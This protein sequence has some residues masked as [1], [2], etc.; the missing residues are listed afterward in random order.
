MAKKSSAAKSPA[1]KV[2]ALQ[3]QVARH[4]ANYQRYLQAGDYKTA[5][6]EAQKARQI[7]SSEAVVA[8]AICLMRLGRAEEA[9]ALA[10]RV[11]PA[12]RDANFFDLVADVCGQLGK[13]EEG[14]AYGK[15]ALNLKDQQNATGY[16]WPLPA[17]APP[18]FTPDPS[19]NIVAYSL[20]GSKP[21]YC[22]G[23]VLNCAAV[24]K[25]L[26]GWTCRFY[27]DQ[28]VPDAVLLRLREAGAQLV[29]VD[30]DT[31]NQV[32]PLMWRFLVVDSPEVRRF[33]IRDADSVVSEREKACIE[34]WLESPSW[35]HLIRDWYTHTELLLAGLWGG[36]TGVFPDMRHEIVSFMTQGK[37]SASHYDQHFLRER[38]WPTVRQSVLSHDSQFEFF[39]NV[40]VPHVE[41]ARSDGEYHIGANLGFMTMEGK[42]THPDGTLIRWTLYDQA[43]NPVCVY[44]TTV[45]QQ[46][47]S[48]NLPVFYASQISDGVCKVRTTPVVAE[49]S[50]S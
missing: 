24:A 27:H 7:G 21:R 17:A 36:C 4:Y 34:A 42:T 48:A 50:G 1:A 41:G 15:L 18:A 14:R 28:S 8:E 22:E 6:V 44:E 26:P 13:T 43:D 35:F 19:A 2:H 11:P 40:P 33:L 31:K 46:R 47:W 25:L 3:K 5:L 23:A 45:Q 37:R 30:D 10:N 38:L 29:R 16:A 9:F 12:K 49:R 20:F 39:N 32:P